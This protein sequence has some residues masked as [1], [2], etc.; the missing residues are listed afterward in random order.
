MTSHDPRRYR[1]CVPFKHLMMDVKPG[2]IV[3]VNVKDALHVQ[4]GHVK[5]KRPKKHVMIVIDADIEIQIIANGCTVIVLPPLEYVRFH[6]GC[7]K[8]EVDI[9]CRSRFHGSPDFDDG[10]CN[11]I[12]AIVS[13]EN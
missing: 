1:G 2:H 11:A 5:I 10:V 13:S 4:A 8:P 3:N 6:S 12:S 9:Y 7:L